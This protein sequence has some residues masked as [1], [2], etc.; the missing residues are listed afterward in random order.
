TDAKSQGFGA[1]LD[2]R[3]MWGGMRMSPT[4]IA[5]VTGATYTY[6]INGHGPE[7][8]WTALFQ[9]GDRVRLRFINAAAM[10][11]FNVRIPGLP[12]TIVQADGLNV[13]PLD[14]D[15]FQ[16]GVAE[17]YDVIV[18]PEADQAFILMAE[19]IDSSGY[20]RATLAP[21]PGMTAPVPA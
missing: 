8:N 7:D 5:D 18:Q 16:I 19:S 21:R 14:V 10:S 17:T 12:M 2:G 1:A 15:E 13:R 4:D 9:P 6:I 3:L 11:I 20:A